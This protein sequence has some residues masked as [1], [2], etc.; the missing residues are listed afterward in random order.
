MLITRGQGNDNRSTV[1]HPGFA[2]DPKV[3]PAHQLQRIK[4]SRCGL[5]RVAHT[6]HQGPAYALGMP[7]DTHDFLGR[8]IELQK[9]LADL[10]VLDAMPDIVGG[11]AAVTLVNESTLITLLLLGLSQLL[12][13]VA[14]LR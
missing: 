14:R 2:G 13:P 7:V 10:A 9:P 1:R 8:T 6:R 11:E 5:R 3:V 4:H 12:E